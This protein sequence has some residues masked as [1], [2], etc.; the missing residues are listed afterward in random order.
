METLKQHTAR[1]WLAW[2]AAARYILFQTL[3]AYHT[4]HIGMKDAWDKMTTWD[5]VNVGCLAILAALG[6]LGA[7]MNGSWQKAKDGVK[8]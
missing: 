5:Y 1:W 4:W 3:V 7:I 8:P 6:A 2:L